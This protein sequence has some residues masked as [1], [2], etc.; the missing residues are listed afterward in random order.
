MNETQTVLL[1]N[2]LTNPPLTNPPLTTVFPTF[3]QTLTPIPLPP[4]PT[5]LIINNTSQTLLNLTQ[6]NQ[7]FYNLTEQF[8]NI[9]NLFQNFSYSFNE[10]VPVNLND[11]KTL[12]YIILVV[13][14]FFNLGTIIGFMFSTKK[15]LASKL[16]RPPPVNPPD[17]V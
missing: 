3:N 2:P 9:T 7:S 10:V 5:S 15:F 8:S 12:Q 16:F 11:I 6:L 17:R 13:I 1:T 4:T 14:V